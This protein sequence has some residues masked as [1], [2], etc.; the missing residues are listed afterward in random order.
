MARAPTA[1]MRLARS[2][3]VRSALCGAQT[4]AMTSRAPSSSSSQQFISR[5][6]SAGSAC[7]ALRSAREC[8]LRQYERSSSRSEGIC[9]SSCDSCDACAAARTDGRR[10]SLMWSHGKETRMTPK[11]PWS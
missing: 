10:S 7:S 5:A 6:R 4:T 9:G 2:R 1:V 3:S 11:K 8:R